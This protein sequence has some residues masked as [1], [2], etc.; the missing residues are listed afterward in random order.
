MGSRY[1]GLILIA[2]AIVALF[3]LF[4]GFGEKEK[5]EVV[6]AIEGMKAPDITLNSIDG[7]ALQISALK[8]SVVFINFWATWC[9]PCRDEMPSLQGLYNNFKDNDKFRMITILYRD[10]PEKAFSYLRENN[11]DLPLWLDPSGKAAVSYGL[12]GVP[13]TFIIDKNGILIKKLIGPADWTSSEI[14]SLISELIKE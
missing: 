12:T 11:F 7:K 5:V 2:I 6:K 4:W 13:E 1:K 8:G 14:I 9:P 3:I 10:E